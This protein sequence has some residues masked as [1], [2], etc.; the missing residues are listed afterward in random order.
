M[1]LLEIKGI[2]VY[3]G[4]MP[5]VRDVSLH[6]D[7]GELVSIVGAN[8]AGKTTTLNTISGLLTPRRGE[9]WFQGERIDTIP[10]HK[11]VHRGIIQIPEGRRLF[12]LM[13]VI[14]N[15]KVGAYSPRAAS[16]M[17]ESLKKAFTFLPKLEER[18]GQLA[19]TLSG[20]EQQLLAIGRGLMGKPR[21]LMLDEPSLGLAPMMVHT[22]FELVKAIRDEGTTVLL[23]EQNV[24]HSLELAHRGYVLENGRITLEGSGQDL[25]S[26]TKVK[27]A[28]LGI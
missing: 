26:N 21:L 16:G 4:D 7:E 6:I 1:S 10:A 24:K 2:D 5:A 18:K 3:Y 25:L 23:V 22:V 17:A 13:S 28:F 19:L 12:P 11:L 15:L 14:E 20:G 9:I 27:S 8:G